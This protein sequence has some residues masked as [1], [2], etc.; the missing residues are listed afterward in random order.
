MR[1]FLLDLASLLVGFLA[2]SV[3]TFGVALPWTAGIQFLRP[4]QSIFP[5]LAIMVGGLALGSFVSSRSWGSGMPR[6]TYG[7]AVSNVTA[8]VVV[9]ALAEFFVRDQFY[10][11][12]TYVAAAAVVTFGAA[13]FHRAIARARPWNEPVALITHEKQLVED[14]HGAPH[15]T[16]V[17]V[18]D[19]ES[20]G[21]S[22]PL[23]HG[24]TLALDL[25]A[26]LSDQMAQFI[27][28]SNLAGFRIRPLVDV[29][30]EHTGRLAIV[31]L[32]EGW[33][34]QTPVQASKTFQTAK[35]AV[36]ATLTVLAAPLALVLGVLVWVAVRLDSKGPAIFHQTRVGRGGRHFTLYKFRT[37]IN[38]A[39]DGGAQFAK[40]ADPRLT[41]VG[42][43]LRKVRMDELPQLWNVLKGDLSLV[44]PRPEQ[45][46]FVEQFS[47]SIPFYDHRH[48]IRPGLTGWAQVSYGYA[49]DEADTIEKLTYDLYYVKHM[50]P[51]L[52]LNILGRSVWTVLSGFGAR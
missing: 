14:L 50:S 15:I 37:M 28:S 26:V 45:P 40:I 2:A 4:G 52:D 8:M 43:V 13:L 11:S 44:G 42:R 25:R 12:R 33:E 41:R 18:L 27:S 32:A 38:G 20:Q 36:D 3:Y 39:D 6:P 21:P 49:D 29:Y 24:T 17:E 35:R 31:H 10:Y 19:P 9:V 5:L 22:G 48:L 34:L 30:E 23:P 1:I 7:R 16:V 46:V 51:W 47:R